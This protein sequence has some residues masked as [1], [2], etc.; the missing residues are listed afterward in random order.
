[1]SGEPVVL[2]RMRFPPPSRL[3]TAGTSG[4]L[5]DAERPIAMREGGSPYHPAVPTAAGWQNQ[6]SLPNITCAASTGYKPAS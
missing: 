6:C 5:P 3:A 2:S 1:M 4:Y